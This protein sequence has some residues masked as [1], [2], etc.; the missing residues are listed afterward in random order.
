MWLG[1]LLDLGAPAVD[2][3]A[4]IDAL[5]MPG[6]RLQTERVTR[7]GLSGTY[8]SFR[9]PDQVPHRAYGA[10]RELLER[11]PLPEPARRT[12][13][14]VVERLGLAEARVHG[15]P[16]EQVHFH[17]LGS[18]DT[19]GDIVGVAVGLDALGVAR[20]TSSPIALGHGHVDTAHGRLPLPA[21]ATLELL[22]GIP[23]YPAHVSWETVTPTGA[24]LLAAVVDHFGPMPGI[25]PAAQGFGAGNDREGPMPN[26]LRGVL[27]EPEAGLATD[28][29][30]VLETHLDDM[31]P[32]LLPFLLERLMEAGALDASL[33]AIT[34]KKGRPGQLLRAIVHPSDRDRIGRE[35]LMH[36]SAIGVRHTE[37][38]RLVLERHARRVRTPYGMIRVK[39]VRT[40]DGHVA[41]APE[42]DACAAAAR[43][44]DVPLAKVYRAAEEAARAAIDVPPT[45]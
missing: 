21:P 32:E 20:V 16:L 3:C 7:R 38:S 22:A 45:T 19:L 33:V 44:H 37:M 8:V 28:V 15:V 17:E 26:L 13:L 6:L 35:I 43:R 10:L 18:W 34:M 2:I 24:A 23:T 14:A 29:V 31:Q 27:S 25:T 40:P 42:Y 4:A 41:A 36:S 12:A 9:A 39:V 11:V 5:G 1:A 30:V